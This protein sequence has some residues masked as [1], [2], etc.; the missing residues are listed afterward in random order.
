MSKRPI[1]ISKRPPFKK[2]R[3]E[4]ENSHLDMKLKD[5]RIEVRRKQRE[6]SV[7]M[8][9]LLPR[10]INKIN[11]A[12]GYRYCNKN[13]RTNMTDEDKEILRGLDKINKEINI[14][15][16]SK[17][18]RILAVHKVLKNKGYRSPGIK[19]GV[20]PRTNEGFVKLVEWLKTTMRKPN[21]YKT[22]PLDRI[23]LLKKVKKFPDVMEPSKEAGD[24][25]S[26]E[27]NL[28]PISIPSIKDRCLQAAYL[29]GYIV[30]SEYVADPNSYAF[31]PG[32]S[33]SWAAMSLAANLR[34][35]STP[36]W[37]VEVDIKKC[38]DN[39]N[40]DFIEKHTPFIPA[41]ILRKWL[42]QGYILRNHENLGAFETVSGIP[43]GGIISPTICN[44]VLDGAESYI[45][46][47]LWIYIREHKLKAN[48][49][50][51]CQ[52]TWRRTEMLFKFYRYADDIVIT[53]KSKLI[54]NLCKMYLAEFLRYR[55]LELSEEKTRLTDVSGNNAYFDFIGYRFSKVFIKEVNRS[56]WFIRIP[57][58]ST[59]RILSKLNDLCHTK[60][61]IESL[62]YE[63]STILIS[64]TSYYAIGNISQD[65]Q[66]LNIWVYNTFYH[67]LERRIKL[68]SEI[69]QLFVKRVKGKKRN[70]GRRKIY[71]IIHTRYLKIIPYHQD[72][73]MKWFVTTL[74]EGNRR[75]KFL[76]FSPRIFKLNKFS[77][78]KILTKQHLNYFDNEDI[79]IITDIN[80]NY[81]YGVR[82]KVL[83]KNY[84]EYHGTLTCPCCLE[85]FYNVGKYEFHHI[86]PVEFGGD[87][88][89]SNLVP[90]CI[91]CHKAISSAVMKRDLIEMTLYKD[92][93]LLDIP[94]EYL[95][96]LT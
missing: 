26:K 93:K 76:L 59:K 25:Y 49:V 90:L 61:S 13:E 54:A 9:N 71:H 68:S 38:Y 48:D 19:G 16:T 80:L 63:F 22:T 94:E 67:A 57:P 55:G 40:H 79:K 64:W 27:K 58:D 30:Y 47:K 14:L 86:L 20:H 2:E 65:L 72:Y 60:R 73:K 43:Q 18:A 5:A 8:K 82:A 45:R 88:K 11:R 36:S 21:K 84:K 41:T 53:T 15:Q 3:F 32:R 69:K 35:N 70:I 87:S 78:A 28:R 24:T 77:S 85:P 62:F 81:K 37:I 95:K 12:L 4:P 29:L 75:R 31:R 83:R 1:A 52:I 92:R 23:Y 96:D 17:A 74:G 66:K 33:A 34:A 56:K 51:Y 42:K 10:D 50:G 89:D 91:P 44:T 46:E 39:I 7:A 6:I